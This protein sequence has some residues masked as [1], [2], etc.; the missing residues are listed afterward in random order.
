MYSIK[1]NIYCDI[2]LPAFLVSKYPFD[3]E[4]VGEDM[5]VFK[6]QFHEGN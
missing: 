3:Y 6:K 1:R 5:M 2:L 4:K